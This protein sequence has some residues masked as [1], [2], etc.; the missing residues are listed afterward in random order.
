MK[1][2]PRGSLSAFAATLLTVLVALSAPSPSLASVPYSCTGPCLPELPPGQCYTDGTP[3]AA[4][5]PSGFD[6]NLELSDWATFYLDARQGDACATQAATKLTQKLQSTLDAYG[7]TA[8]AGPWRLVDPRQGNASVH[9]FRSWL[10]GGLITHIFATAK[11]LDFQGVAVPASLPGLLAETRAIYDG[12]PS[13]QD[14]SCG[15]GSLPNVNSCMDDHALTASGYA[16]IAALEYA[17]FRSPDAWVQKA[18]DEIRWALSPMSVNNSA[19]HGGGPCFQSLIN[20]SP[21]NCDGTWATYSANP[22]Q[23]RIIGVDHGQENPSYGLGLMTSIASACAGLYIGNHTCA[24]DTQESTVAAQLF[25]HGQAKTSASYVPG[26]NTCAFNPAQQGGCLSFTTGAA[27][28]CSDSATFGTESYRPSDYPVK[29]FYDKRM[30]TVPANGYQFDRYCDNRTNYVRPYDNLW[31]PNRKVLYDLLAYEIFK[32]DTVAPKVS[33]VYPTPGAL[34]AGTAVFS[35]NAS[36]NLKINR[37]EYWLEGASSP[38]Y[39][40]TAPPWT[41]PVDTSSGNV[42]GTY[43]MTPIA[44]DDAGNFTVGSSATFRVSNPHPVPITPSTVYSTL[45]IGAYGDNYFCGDLGEPRRT[46]DFIC[47]QKGY[48]AGAVSFTVAAKPA[49]SFCAYKTPSDTPYSGLSGNLGNGTQI[50]S[51]VAC[52]TCGAAS[53]PTTVYATLGFLAYGDNYFCG[54]IGDIQRT[55][56]F[57]C[58]PKGYFSALTYTVT[59]KPVG[60]YCAYKTPG[61]APYYGLV[62]NQGSG[63]QIISRVAC[64]TCAGYFLAGTVYSTLAIPAYGDNYFCGDLGNLQQTASFICTQKGYARGAVSYSTA[65]KPAGSFCAYKTSADTPNWGLSGNLGNGNRVLTQVQCTQ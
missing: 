42:D 45:G 9:V 5:N 2:S 55:A 12:I 36:D 26:G 4:A 57:I 43:T 28:D 6:L 62:G 25:I 56:D 39:I 31:G 3:V 20:P 52:S 38:T 48:A 13:P 8:A 1:F 29:L 22:G 59:A 64:S 50:I 65:P 61:S 32:P 44:Y 15:S 21:A 14:V 46:A 11:E 10:A 33:L 49:G 19:P 37:V 60:S 30:V 53:V 35:V 27:V 18:Q 24:F 58:T 47:A 41:F 16:W 40:A 23:Y 34:V 51:Q 54:D 7:H 17:Q 63:T